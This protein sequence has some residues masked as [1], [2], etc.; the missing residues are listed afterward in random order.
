MHR[1]PRADLEGMTRERHASRAPPAYLGGG[2]G[3]ESRSADVRWTA[4]RRSTISTRGGEARGGAFSNPLMC[5]IKTFFL[6]LLRS[7]SRL[8]TV[9]QGEAR[10]PL[11]S[12]TQIAMS[13][14]PWGEPFR[15]S[16]R[17]GSLLSPLGWVGGGSLFSSPLYDGFIFSSSWRLQFG[18][19]FGPSGGSFFRPRGGW[20]PGQGHNVQQK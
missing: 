17:R 11:G 4:S 14:V 13:G 18:I 19:W 12:P 10:R 9:S 5:F 3:R 15:G 7:F 20:G 6:I 2:E 8:I 1:A 16:L